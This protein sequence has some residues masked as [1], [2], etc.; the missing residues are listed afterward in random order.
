MMYWKMKP[1]MVQGMSGQEMN[2]YTSCC[3]QNIEN[4][5]FI[6][7]AG[8]MAPVPLN[9]TGRLNVRCVSHLIADQMANSLDI[10][11]DFRR[12][13]FGQEVRNDRSDSTNQEK[14][15]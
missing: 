9:I 15:R 11:E 8:G 7:E 4:V 12:I 1:T 13:P 10:L 6:A 2:Q 3:E 5:Q 14:E